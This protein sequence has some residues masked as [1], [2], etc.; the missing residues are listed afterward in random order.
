M[1]SCWNWPFIITWGLAGIFSAM[2]WVGVIWLISLM[3]E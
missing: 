1:K 2:F 3:I